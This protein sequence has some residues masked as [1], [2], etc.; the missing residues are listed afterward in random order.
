M[1][2]FQPFGISVA[3]RARLGVNYGKHLS[4]ASY[5]SPRGSV[6]FARLFRLPHRVSS[7]P[8]V[9]GSPVYI[10]S[11]NSPPRE[12]SNFSFKLLHTNFV[13]THFIYKLQPPNHLQ[14]ALPPLR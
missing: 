8:C 10:K 14:N 5:E 7:L 12:D 13:S 3:E 4:G 9:T 11:D 2:V 6:R 1:E